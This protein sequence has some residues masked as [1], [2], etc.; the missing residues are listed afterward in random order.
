MPQ[1]QY[2][3]SQ[4]EA[5]LD[6]LTNLEKSIAHYFLQ[7]Q[8]TL[9]DLS[10]ATV[11][12][13]LHVSPAALTRFAK[14]SGFSGYREFTFEYQNTQKQLEESFQHIQKDLTKR[15]LMD[16][17]EIIDKTNDLVDED[18]LERIATMLDKASRV[19]FYGVGSS[20]LVAKETKLRFMRLGLVCEAVSDT[21][22][23]IWTNSILDDS[24][25]VFG[26]SLTG[27][28]QAILTSLTT[29]A[30]KG[31]KTV[32]ISAQAPQEE[33]LFD[34]HVPVASVRHLNYGNRIS[35]QLPLLMILDVLYAYYLAIDKTKKET[36]FKDTI[37]D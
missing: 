1:K 37:I 32:L 4:I 22:N 28:T 29:A 14:K 17:R 3:I 10:A 7:G 8:T 31:A 25:L 36:I 27:Q 26:L 11:S 12:Q 5:N 34:E 15:V 35:P 16:Y 20:G 24:C 21:E 2:I 23:L 13:T 9:T 19:Y 33:H 6:K 18:K 30:N